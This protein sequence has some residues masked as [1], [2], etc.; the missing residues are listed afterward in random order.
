MSNERDKVYQTIIDR[1]TGHVVRILGE[2]VN[3][4]KLFTLPP[5]DT[6][7]WRYQNYEFIR[8]IFVDGRLY[9]RRADKFKD[10]LEGRFTA[11]N[12]ERPS[13]MFAAAAGQLPMKQVVSIQE[14]HRSHV[15][16]N[17]WHKNP[18]ENERMWR[19]YTTCAEAIAVKTELASLFAATPA[20][21]KGANVHYIGEGDSIPELHS[22][23]ALVHKRR[24]P[25]EF[26]NEFR[27]IYQ[28]PP[29][30]IN[31]PDDKTDEYRW[32]PV[33]ARSLLHLIRFHPAAT[34]EFMETVRRDLGTAGLQVPSEPS[35]VA[36]SS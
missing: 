2:V 7:L 22:L 17:C 8:S 19:E 6:A 9:F 36:R 20:Q 11:G 26:E 30:E 31:R 32:V 3:P 16:L 18:M 27:L 21:I 29:E 28:L 5:Q 10:R 4:E 14:S 34:P 13:I 35:A 33:D 24:D 23:A 15:Y 1:K 25:F 12:R